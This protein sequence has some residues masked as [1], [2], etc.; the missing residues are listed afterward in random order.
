MPGGVLRANDQAQRS[1]SGGSLGI[2]FIITTLAL[3]LFQR[4]GEAQR[5]L[6]R[7]KP[8]VSPQGLWS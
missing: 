8:V 3:S 5:V 1:S 6:D 7:F 4:T 2:G